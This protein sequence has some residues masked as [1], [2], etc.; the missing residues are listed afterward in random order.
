MFF[1]KIF[2]DFNEIFI[3]FPLKIKP[4]SIFIY[5]LTPIL[6]PYISLALHSF[7]ITFFSHLI[8]AARKDIILIIHKIQIISL[9]KFTNLALLSNHNTLFFQFINIIQ[10]LFSIFTITILLFQLIFLFDFFLIKA[11]LF[12]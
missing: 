1:E 12:F 7:S 5:F 4:I 2:F 11:F 3:F 9:F 6:H 10:L 8:L